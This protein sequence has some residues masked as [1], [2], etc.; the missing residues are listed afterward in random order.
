V[1]AGDIAFYFNLMKLLIGLLHFQLP[2]ILRKSFLVADFRLKDSVYYNC[3]G[4][5]RY[6]IILSKV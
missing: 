4:Q 3:K 5:F 6:E 2:V 1:R